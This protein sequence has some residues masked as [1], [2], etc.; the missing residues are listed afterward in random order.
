M[1]EK[2]KMTKDL[3]DLVQDLRDEDKKAHQEAA[4]ALGQLET[5]RAVDPLIAA[6]ADRDLD[7]RRTAVEALVQ[8]GP[9]AIATLKDETWEVRRA[10]AKALGEVLNISISVMRS[11]SVVKTSKVLIIDDEPAMLEVMNFLLKDEGF[12]VEIARDGVSGIRL[13]KEKHP[14]IILLDVMMPNMDGWEVCRRLREITDVP[15]IFVTAKGA[16]EHVVKGFSLGAE[17]YVIKPFRFSELV[18][19]MKVC[20]KKVTSSSTDETI[21]TLKNE[22]E[23]LRL[24]RL[25]LLRR[26]EAQETSNGTRIA[27]VDELSSLVSGIVHDLRGGLGVIRNTAGFMLDDVN[28]DETLATD[29]D[30][31]IRTT[32]FCELVIRNL[33]S[34]GGDAVFEP[35]EVN[36]EQVVRDVYFMLERK[37]VDVKMNVDTEADTPTIRAD[38]G[39]MKQIF[40]NL[41]KNAGEA[42]P[43]GGTLTVR[44]HREGQ[45]L[46]IEVSDTGCGISPEDQDRLFQEFFTTKERGYGLGLH[47]VHTI[48]KRHGGTIEVESEI[49]KGTTFVLHL[50]IEQE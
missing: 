38:E 37:L 16:V 21:T 40:M 4:Q 39:Q 17:D 31:V 43:E 22:I 28:Q 7:V 29:L 30:K 10:A 36:I 9:P 20:L 8:I 13:A 47:I 48:V 19:R 25:E 42:M 49:D 46:C 14:N 45:L 11:P 33:M 12:E 34:L 15:I 41:I 18:S 26:I 50:P 1:R 6:L 2:G 27:A 35:V 24:Q 5:S 3:K 44:T 23:R 32:E